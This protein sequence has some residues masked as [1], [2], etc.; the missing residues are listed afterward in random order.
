MTILLGFGE[1]GW[2]TRGSTAKMVSDAASNAK[3]QLAASICVNRFNQATDAASQLVALRKTE[4]W[5][6]S[7][8]IE[9]RGW[10]T[11]PGTSAPVSGAAD[12]CAQ[13]LAAESAPTTTASPTTTVAAT[14]GS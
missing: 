8:F 9:K 13:R 4:F 12:L 2:Q 1:A 7:E 11:L 5:Q 6:R 10:A 14:P 3:T